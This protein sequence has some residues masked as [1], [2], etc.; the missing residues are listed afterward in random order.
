MIDWAALGLSS[1]RV[2]HRVVSISREPPTSRT[3]THERR[4]VGMPSGIAVR[5]FIWLHDN[6]EGVRFHKYYD[7]FDSVS[8][9]VN[10]RWRYEPEIVHRFKL[11]TDGS[12]RTIDASVPNRASVASRAWASQPWRLRSG[13]TQS[14][15]AR[16][17]VARREGIRLKTR[18]RLYQC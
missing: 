3:G 15:C 9:S 6:F 12:I 1:R 4:A 16:A 18:H 8:L 5:V 2:C 13:P 14:V 10:A 11:A 7:G 17:R